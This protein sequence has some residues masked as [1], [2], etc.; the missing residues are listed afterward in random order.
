[1][2]NPPLPLIGLSLVCAFAIVG[3]TAPEQREIQIRDA[4]GRSV[5]VST[6]VQRIVS[7][8]PS[9]TEVVYVAGGGDLLVGASTADDYPPAVHSLPRFGVNPLNLE[10][11]L[12]VE[13]HLVLATDQI[14]H[15]D[16]V[17]PLQ[18]LGIPTYFFSFRELA[19]VPRAVRRLGELM[20]TSHVADARADSLLLLIDSLSELTTDVRSRPR[21]LLLAGIDPL[22]A[23]G[24]GSYVHDVVR[25]AGGESLT[26]DIPTPA[27]LLSEEYVL[28]SGA[29]VI[30]GADTSD[31]TAER[32]SELR[33]TWDLIPAISDGRVYPIHP[34][35]LF[36]P[37]PRLIEGAYRIAQLLHPHLMNAGA[38]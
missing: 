20:G 26:R 5:E 4:L 1:M 35:L 33:P 29:D 8:A 31:F 12:A 30:I 32:L 28:R 27:P 6:P 2:C 22:Y 13:P 19:D 34:D 17:E 9:M 11:I 24:R 36:R 3:C 15:P 21:V 23:F 37:G 18:R 16:Q 14:N 38:P 7:L 25:R 10:A